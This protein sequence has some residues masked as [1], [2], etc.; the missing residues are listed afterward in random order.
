MND[1]ILTALNYIDPA[2]LDYGEWLAVGMDIYAYDFSFETFVEWS[3]PDPRFNY[4]VCLVKWRS[5]KDAKP[6]KT[7]FKFA[8]ANGWQPTQTEYRPPARPRRT[9]PAERID[10][11]TENPFKFDLTAEITAAHENILRY[12]EKTVK[13]TYDGKTYQLTPLQYITRWR[14]IPLDIVKSKMIG[15][16]P[17]GHNDIL[18]NYP[19]YQSGSK[20]APYYKIVFPF[21]NGNGGYNYFTT[22]T[23]DRTITTYAGKTAD[24][25][26]KYENIHKYLKPRKDNASNDKPATVPAI[27]AEIYNEY[28]LKGSEVPPFIFICEGIFDALS[29]EAAGGSAIALN[30]VGANRLLSICKTFKPDT[31][32]IIALDNDGAGQKAIERLKR[33]FDVLNVRYIIRQAP[34]PYKDFNECLQHDTELLRRYVEETATTTDGDRIAERIITT[35]NKPK[36]DTRAIDEYN[37]RAKNDRKRHKNAF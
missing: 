37:R 21:Y 7:I 4:N 28:L 25:A 10:P 34:K 19:E 23:I 8:R 2:T 11:Y 31:L 33:D 29:I 22:E 1:E 35:W 14:K 15:Y 5:F 13:T 3:K 30:G 6:S 18:I 9:D 26:P 32:F 12:E 27:C 16:A 24:G 36:T 20:N 17:G